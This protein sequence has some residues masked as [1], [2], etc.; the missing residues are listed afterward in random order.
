MTESP[1]AEIQC[2]RDMARRGESAA[3]MFRHLKARLGVGAHVTDLIQC[4][5]AA[6]C[7][8]LAEVKPVA[9]LT[10]TADRDVIDEDQLNRLVMPEIE[11][12]RADWDR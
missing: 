3:T 8:N 4:F 6:F 11:R 1:R 10:R 2:L 5:R 7:L 12:H 9:A